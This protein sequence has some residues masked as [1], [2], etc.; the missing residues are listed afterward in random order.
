MRRLLVAALAL[1]LSACGPDREP[2]AQLPSPTGSPTSST[3]TTEPVD[4]DHPVVNLLDWQPVD[5]GPTDTVTTNGTVSITVD[6]AGRTV[7]FTGTDA[8]VDIP[9]ARRLSDVL[10]DDTY[11]VIVAQDEQEQQPSVATLIT[12]ATGETHPIPTNANGGTWTLSDGRVL[13]AVYAAKHRYCLASLDAATLTETLTYC[14]PAR[15]GFTDARITP[16]GTSLLTFDSRPSGYCRTPSEVEDSV[17]PLPDIEPCKGWDSL[18]TPYGRIWSVVPKPNQVEQADFFATS[19]DGMVDLGVGTTGS[20][21]WCG[22]SAYFVRDSQKDV[23][24]A[25]LLRWAPEHTLEV[26]YESPGEG[27]AFLSAPRCAGNVIT[28]SEQGEGG[29]EQVSASVP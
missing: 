18:L 12:L 21:T 22:D 7:T 17:T 25:R 14:A 1:G 13:H 20:L 16:A 6:Q 2:V 11:A 5:A 23:D 4:P 15:H 10:L 26:V 29:D 3:P 28:I 9:A 27:N 24:K 8:T 19:D